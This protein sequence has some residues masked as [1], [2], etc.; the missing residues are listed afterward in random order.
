MSPSVYKK[1]G[2]ASLIMMSSV[3][4]S[5]L[6]GLVGLLALRVRQHLQQTNMI[7]V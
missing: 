4:L 2:I 7:I 3:F 1:V 6:I 5:N